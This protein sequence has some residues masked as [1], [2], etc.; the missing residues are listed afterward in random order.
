MPDFQLEAY[1]GSQSRYTSG[2]AYQKLHHHRLGKEAM[3]AGL[4]IE[5]PHFVIW[6][7][8]SADLRRRFR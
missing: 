8:G 1:E 6:R 5:S 2:D 4:G 7:K 3:G